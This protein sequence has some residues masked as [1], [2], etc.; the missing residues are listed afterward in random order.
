M[1]YETLL[2]IKND[3]SFIAAIASAFISSA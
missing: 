2:V 3:R 1:F